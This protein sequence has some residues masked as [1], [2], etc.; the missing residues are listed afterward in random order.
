MR[1]T[2]TTLIE[3]SPGEHT[4]L[5]TEHGLS[6]FIETDETALLFD[7]GRS[8][9]FLHNAQT[10]QLDMQKIEHVVLSHGH[11]DH[12]GGFK[13]FSLARP[14]K[15]Y[16]VWVGEGFFNQKLAKFGPSFQ[17]LGND[18]D[19]QYLKK[20]DILH[21]EIS[22]DMVEISHGIWIVKNFTKEVKQLTRNERFV[23]FDESSKSYVVDDFHDEILLVLET[24]KGLVVL[25]GCSHPGILN[26]INTVSRN[27]SQPI[28]AL[29]GGTHLVEASMDTIEEAIEDIERRSIEVVGISH[30]TGEHAVCRMQRRTKGFFHNCTGSSITIF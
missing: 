17:F 6:F 21:H 19:Q 24:D 23:V 7:T 8:N 12:T 9:A 26:M 15:R 11:Y 27:F 5:H 2:I 18:F 13:A 10:L 4:G 16:E 20:H 25:V 28:Y 30:C 29:L 22:S 14:D 3:N 1:V